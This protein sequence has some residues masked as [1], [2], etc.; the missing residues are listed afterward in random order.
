MIKF[1]HELKNN[2][3]NIDLVRKSTMLPSAHV[4]ALVA[5]SPLLPLCW[6]SDLSSFSHSAPL[7]GLG[8]EKAAAHKKIQS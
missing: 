1:F 6:T 8:H 2:C 7:N 4:F 3:F 5:E